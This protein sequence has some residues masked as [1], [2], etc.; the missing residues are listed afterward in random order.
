MSTLLYVNFVPFK[1]PLVQLTGTMIVKARNAIGVKILS[2]N[3]E[4]K[5]KPHKTTKRD[6]TIQ[7]PKE[8]K[9]SVVT[10]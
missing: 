5:I 6:E 10:C 2:L 9:H 4:Q 1:V 3:F 7:I 8:G